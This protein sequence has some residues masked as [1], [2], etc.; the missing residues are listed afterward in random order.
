[1][2]NN[3][4]DAFIKQTYG[5]KE[6]AM[7]ADKQANQRVLDSKARAKE[8]ERQAL[9]QFSRNQNINSAMP[10]PSKLTN[11]QLNEKP[12]AHPH[13]ANYNHS[14]EMDRT[15]IIRDK[16]LDEKYKNNPS[17]RPSSDIDFKELP[18]GSVEDA[19]NTFSNDD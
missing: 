14:L 2:S 12:V 16:I 15:K 11:G 9:L 17:A 5:S 13:F 4:Q 6:K 8:L 1:M 10:I 19:F 18:T 7:E 3:I